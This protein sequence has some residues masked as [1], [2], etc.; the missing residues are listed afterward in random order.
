MK[1]FIEKPIDANLI[2][3]FKV[4]PSGKLSKVSELTRDEA[5][6]LA[7]RLLELALRL[8]K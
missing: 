5:I 6:G 2:L 1:L 4:T 3:A 8:D 7:A